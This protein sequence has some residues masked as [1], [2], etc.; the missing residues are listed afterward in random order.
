MLAENFRGA[1]DHRKRRAQFVAGGRGEGLF[2]FHEPVQALEKAVDRVGDWRELVLRMV[3]SEALVAPARIDVLQSLRQRSHRGEDAARDP[4]RGRRHDDQGHSDD[5]VQQ[6]PCP[7]RALFMQRDIERDVHASARQ[8]LH[9]HLQ[10]FPRD[11]YALMT[12]RAESGKFTRQIG[13]AAAKERKLPALRRYGVLVPLDIP[14]IHSEVG[15]HYI[16]EQSLLDA[17]TR[18][19]APAGEQQQRQP[20]AEQNSPDDP[21]SKAEVTHQSD[22]ARR[23]PSP[24]CVCRSL[25]ANGLSMALRSAYMWA[26]STSPSGGWS[27]HSS[28]SS[29]RRDTTRCVFCI[30]NTSRRRV[31]GLSLIATPSRSALRVS[32]Q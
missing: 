31:L 24:W 12:T 22:K 5:G 30:S 15:S 17:L 21:R 10:E 3:W 18:P 4:D 16:V 19:D 28:C 29:S 11:R 23:Y 32:G 20:D 9:Q 26:R 14:G 6:S 1:L 25:R 13:R 7:Q 27:P 8:V 2:A